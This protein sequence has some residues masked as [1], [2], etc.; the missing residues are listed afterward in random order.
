[1][2]VVGSTKTVSSDVPAG[3]APPCV[4]PR[5]RTGVPAAAGTPVRIADRGLKETAAAGGA[6]RSVGT[7]DRLHKCNTVFPFAKTGPCSPFAER[8]PE[9]VRPEPRG[10]EPFCRLCGGRGETVRRGEVSFCVDRR[11]AA[12]RPSVRCRQVAYL[13]QGDDRVFSV[14]FRTVF[15]ARA[16]VR[17]IAKFFCF[18]NFAL[19]CDDWAVCDKSVLVY[20]LR[21]GYLQD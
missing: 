3:K 14:P 1:M 4:W 2:R 18:D 15:R 6:V 5:P 7:F 11:H 21:D 19:F 12:H 17:R 13:G 8:T 9:F 10:E 16:A 20:I